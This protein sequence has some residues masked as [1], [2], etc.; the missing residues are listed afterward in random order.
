MSMPI[1]YSYRKNRVENISN[2]I[3]I[4]EE[5]VMQKAQELISL[6]KSVAGHIWMVAEPDQV[7]SCSASINDRR[8]DSVCKKYQNEIRKLASK[9]DSLPM[10]KFL[11]KS[12]RWTVEE[13]EKLIEAVKKHEDSQELGIE[14]QVSPSKLLMTTSELQTL[15]LAI[16]HHGHNW[17]D[18]SSKYF[19]SNRA[20]ATLKEL[21]FTHEKQIKSPEFP[22]SKL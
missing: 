18:I 2:D 15:E 12:A 13:S 17:N 3:D 8:S 4:Y 7:I 1:E 14:D 16:E 21:F 6:F 22:F 5:S 9:K 20:L 19:N 10:T 11:Q